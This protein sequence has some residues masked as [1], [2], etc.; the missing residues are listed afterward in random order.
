MPIT[1]FTSEF[2]DLILLH[3]LFILF[4][5]LFEIFL[6]AAVAPILHASLPISARSL[7]E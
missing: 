5:N 1:L 4:D 6:A 7:G 3:I 2:A